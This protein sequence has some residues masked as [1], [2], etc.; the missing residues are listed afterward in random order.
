MRSPAAVSDRSQGSGRVQCSGI[1]FLTGMALRRLLL[2][3][4]GEQVQSPAAVSDRTQGLA[5]WN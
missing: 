4:A 5:V 2:L 3:E 1:V